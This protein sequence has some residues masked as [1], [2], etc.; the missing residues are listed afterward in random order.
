MLYKKLRT[1][2][3]IYL[4]ISGCVPLH[5]QKY[6]QQH[7]QRL[8]PPVPPV[9]SEPTPVV[10][11]AAERTQ[12]SHA[13]QDA[14]TTIYV[15]D[16][17]TFRLHL[18]EREVWEAVLSVLMRNYSPLIADKNQ[19]IFATEWDSYFLN[20][21]VYRNKISLRLARGGPGITD[22]TI[23]NSVE[24]LPGGAVPVSGA[25]VTWLPAGDPADEIGRIVKNMAIVLGQPAPR[26]QQAR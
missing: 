26:L 8:A 20:G 15:V 3:V 4:V 22:M 14:A 1:I 7:D 5:L 17:D 21:I 23:H 10:S 25:S 2:G 6:R 16:K 18:A 9:V 19:G 12:D 24:Q 13:T 11:G